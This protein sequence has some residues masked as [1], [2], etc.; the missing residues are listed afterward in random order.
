MKILHLIPML[1]GVAILLLGV[2]LVSSHGYLGGTYLPSLIGIQPCNSDSSSSL[3]NG[4]G[5]TGFSPYGGYGVG[6]IVCIFGLG[7]IGSS[8][9]RAV[10]TPSASSATVPPEVLAALTQAQSRMQAAPGASAPGPKPGTVYCSKCGA[11]NP[12]EAKFCHQCASSMPG[13]ALPG[14]PPMPPTRPPGAG[15]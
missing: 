4:T 6:T 1:V 7:L 10:V 9:R 12:A 14:Q 15:T 8:L 5:C 2:Y 11:A 3:P 13:T